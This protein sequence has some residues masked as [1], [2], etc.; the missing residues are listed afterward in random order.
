[1]IKV[2]NYIVQHLV[3]KHGIEHCF[4]VTGGGAMHLNDAIGHTPGLTFIC[5]HNE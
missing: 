5:N 4:L 1:M 3:E 2:S